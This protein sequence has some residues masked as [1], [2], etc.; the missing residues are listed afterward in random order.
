[1]PI[2]IAKL[3]TETSEGLDK[4]L[5][6]HYYSRL[7]FV[8]NL[9][10]LL[11]KAA[12]EKPPEGNSAPISRVFS[13]LGGGLEGNLN[14]ND[15]SLKNNFSLGNCANHGITMTTL[16]FNKLA[17]SNPKTT[18]VHTQPGGVE[19]NIV[20]NL[21]PLIQTALKGALFVMRPWVMTAEESGERHA[22][23]AT[24]DK[25]GKGGT[26]L[27]GSKGDETTP[28]K[29]VQE[30]KGNGTEEKVWEHTLKVFKDI[31]ESPDGKYDGN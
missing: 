5:S 31:G 19:T 3:L 10:P 14:L 6:L 24:V 17:A 7:R 22:W 27:I 16:S 8:Q 15:L 30:S 1:L 20:R 21:N 18:F 2:C 4:K 11:N 23:A 13:I 28:P 29:V 25:Y 26:V 9:L 12:E